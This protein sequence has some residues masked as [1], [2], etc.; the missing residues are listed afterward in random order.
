MASR[1][2]YASTDSA[3][4][5]AHRFANEILF[6]RQK[7]SGS[8]VS[9]IHHDHYHWGG[10]PTWGY[11]PQPIYCDHLAGGRGRYDKKDQSWVAIP[12]TIVALGSLYFIGQNH[13]EWSIANDDMEQ[14]RQTNLTVRIELSQAHP[15]LKSSVF[16]VFQ[17]QMAILEEVR[18]N[19]I[20]GLL[21]KG[22]L[23]TSVV[24][25]GLGGLAS[26]GIVFAGSLEPLLEFGSIS[27]FI[28]AAAMLYRAGFSSMDR[29]IQEKAI[30][31]Q[32]AVGRA[33]RVL[34][35]IA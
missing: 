29:S 2:S 10:Y 7:T 15:A 28:A 4:R 3:L 18:K 17:K 24:L 1:L 22:F 32:M 11:F 27:T 25:A 5:A 6:T 13:A 33:E 8:S 35:E 21:L 16:S 31:L 30:D 12:A 9:T 19:A 34:N 14:L 26:G 23:L 20:T